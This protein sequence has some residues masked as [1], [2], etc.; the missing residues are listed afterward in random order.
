MGGATITI[1]IGE[2]GQLQVSGN[3]L[4][5]KLLVFGMLEVARQCLIDMGKQNEQLV[6]PASMMLPKLS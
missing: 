4:Q 3:V 6:Q 2:N 1:T 5:N